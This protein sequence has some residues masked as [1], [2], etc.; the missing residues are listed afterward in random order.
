MFQ[1]ASAPST[2]FQAAASSNGG[3]ATILTGK[4]VDADESCKPDPDAEVGPDPLPPELCPLECQPSE[5][6]GAEEIPELV[7]ANPDLSVVTQ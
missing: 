2:F 6:F 3:S 4:V 1:A 5:M 7:I